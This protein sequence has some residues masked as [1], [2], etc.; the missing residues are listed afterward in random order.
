MKKKAESTMPVDTT[1]TF[2]SN[3]GL[4]NYDFFEEYNEGV[5]QSARLPQARGL[6]NLPGDFVE[7]PPEKLAVDLSSDIDLSDVFPEEEEFPEG[8]LPDLDWDELPNEA[9]TEEST[10]DPQLVGVWREEDS[11]GPGLSPDNKD[12]NSFNLR[13]SLPPSSTILKRSL[14]EIISVVLRA[15]REDA[16]GVPFNTVINNVLDA[17]GKEAY[18]VKEVL[19]KLESE[20]NLNGKVFIRAD[21]YPGCENNIWTDHVRSKC[22]SAKYLVT[23]SK[24]K[25]CVLNQKTP[26]GNMCS[27][28]KKA[29]VNQV[30]WGKALQQYARQLGIKV[31]ST[32]PKEELQKIL[33]KER[34]VASTT[35]FP[36]H[37][38]EL[39]R[40]QPKVRTIKK[41]EDVKKEKALLKLANY[42]DRLV[43]IGRISH[44]QK[45]NIFNSYKEGKLDQPYVKIAK[46]ISTTKPKEFSGGIYTGHVLDLN[47]RS[48]KA[49]KL[50]ASEKMSLSNINM[51]SNVDD[52]KMNLSKLTKKAS[53]LEFKSLSAPVDNTA[54]D[55][56]LGEGAGY[57]ELNEDHTQSPLSGITFD[58]YTLE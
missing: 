54:E 32:K 42:L 16:A 7:N 38:E 24:C 10:E 48:L 13:K 12:L 56:G 21:F 1:P 28:F 31:A 8:S 3:Y 4:D 39:P 57:I 58:G 46:V 2:G 14:Q 52:L 9:P 26:E 25:D 49:S 17:L 33:K 34:K 50:K 53:A 5:E 37:N 51:N 29:A 40:L 22:A 36:K 11:K 43:N 41:A 23:G 44:T 47:K 18:R 45:D 6:A 55:W 15:G 30:P 20:K 19:A 27:I 35:Y